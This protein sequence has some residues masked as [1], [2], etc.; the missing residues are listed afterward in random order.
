MNA[1]ASAVLV[2]VD[3]SQEAQHAVDW[4][5]ADA[6]TTG[7][8]VTVVHVVPPLS[9]AVMDITPEMGRYLERRAQKMLNATVQRAE[10]VTPGV[11]VD[12]RL[13]HG[14][15]PAE[16]ITLADEADQ[17]VLGSRGTGG[18]ASLLLGSVGAEVAAHAR[19]PT[20]IVRE[21]GH[22]R[23]PV[24]VGVDGSERGDS[25]LEYG[26]AYAARHGLA[27]QAL[28]TYPYYV[29]TPPFPTRPVD[30]GKLRDE[31]EKVAQ[32]ALGRWS[33]KFPDVL[34]E[35]AVAQGGA[36]RHLLEGSEGSSLLAVGCRGH[37]GFAGLLLGSVSQAVIR[38]A[39][40]PVV[41]TR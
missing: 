25:A 18:F 30:V 4:A 35:W 34:S 16:L 7:S 41:V 14:N 32:D 15:P 31:A 19:R 24:I 5:V 36:A 21:Q 9:A 27:L 38:H 22:R 1:Q 11:K 8:T 37:G 39:H 12:A 2:G 20:V 29:V 26:F 28:H 23:G 33:A 3:E 6:A 40:C 13:L 10:Q 17:V